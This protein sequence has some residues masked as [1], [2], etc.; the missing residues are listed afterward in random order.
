MHAERGAAMRALI[1][2]VCLLVLTI[3]A[4]AQP[5]PIRLPN[6]CWVPGTAA[7]TQTLEGVTAFN[8]DDFQLGWNWVAPGNCLRRGV[9]ISM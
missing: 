5:R 8:E 6:L 1:V 4:A 2:G 9:A 7:Y 3:T